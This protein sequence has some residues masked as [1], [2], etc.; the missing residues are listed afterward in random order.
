MESVRRHAF[1]D[2]MPSQVEIESANKLRSILA[3][4][5]KADEPIRLRLAVEKGQQAEIVLAPALAKTFMELLRYVGGGLAVT[6]VPTQHMLTTQQAADL[7]NVSR[8]YLI[9]LLEQNKMKVEMVGRHRRIRA[10]DLFDYRKRRDN[11]RAAAL[12]ELAELD[13]DLI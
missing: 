12:S 6:V 5:L 3:G 2:R 8:P 9:K 4:Q 1:N 10:Q 13:S 11:E 7:L